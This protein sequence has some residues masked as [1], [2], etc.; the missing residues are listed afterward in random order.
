MSAR[1]GLDVGATKVLGVV[2]DAQDGVVAEVREPSALGVD[3][4]VATVAKV[5]DELRDLAGAEPRGPIGV[6]VPGLVD[7]ATGRVQHAVNL[8]LDESAPLRD[9][10]ADR[11]D[12]PVVLE[13][14]VNAAALGAA[15]VLG[16][17]DLALLSIGTGLAAGLVLDGVLRRGRHGAAGE[18]GHVPVDPAGR[19]CEC[20][21]VGCLETVASGSSVTRAWPAT[22]LPPAVA[23]FAAAA[24]GDR[25]ALAVQRDLG[26]GVAAA[27]RTLCLTVDVECVVLGGGVAQLGEPLAEVVRE[28]LREQA[29]GSAFL[30]ALDLA[31]RVVVVPDGVP[32]AAVGA[33]L[34]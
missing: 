16:A 17:R 30:A 31:S 19:R 11:L 10:L 9:L 1:F 5:V 33:A 26:A 28:A 7:V 6:G 15:R 21:Q 4:V 34:S 32:V 13:N 27:V 20:G 12:H 14:D 25:R 23:L 18:I 22:D 2:L 8:G 3:G 29:R 24:A